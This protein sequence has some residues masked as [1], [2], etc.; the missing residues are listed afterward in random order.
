MVRGRSAEARWAAGVLSGCTWVGAAEEEQ[1]LDNDG[2]GVPVRVDCNDDRA[3]V[4][5]LDAWTGELRCGETVHGDLADGVD[6]LEVVN[7]RHPL[8]P[9]E[10]LVRLAEVE[11]AW[12]LRSDVPTDVTVTLDAPGFVWSPDADGIALIAVRGPTCEVGACVVGLPIDLE[13]SDGSTS[14]HVSFHGDA[15]EA[16]YVVVSGDPRS[17]GY[18]L[19]ARCP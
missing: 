11:D 8:Y 7:C 10:D 12:R 6:R 17:A 15:A 5:D 14:A 3:A 2:D 13:V 16:W 1:R 19:T 4:V 9:T 18:D